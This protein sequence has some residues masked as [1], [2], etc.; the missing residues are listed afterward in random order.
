MTVEF[1]KCETPASILQMLQ[2]CGPVIIIDDEDPSAGFAVHARIITGIHGD[3]DAQNTHLKIVDPDG[4]KTYDESFQ[5]FTSKYE[6]MAHASGRNLQI[7]H[8]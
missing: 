8:Y 3:G 4:G 1:Q 7:M 6:V 2:N 5:D